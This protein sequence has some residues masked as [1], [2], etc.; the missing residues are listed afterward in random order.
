[1]VNDGINYEEVNLVLNIAALSL[2]VAN[3]TVTAWIGF[4]A[5]YAVMK[6]VELIGISKEYLATAKEIQESSREYGRRAATSAEETK[7]VL[8]ERVAGQD[9]LQG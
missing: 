9:N 2:I 5:W 6:A 1:M 7:Q 3:I 4:K 8:K